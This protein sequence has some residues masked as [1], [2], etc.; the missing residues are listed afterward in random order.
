MADSIKLIFKFWKIRVYKL[1]YNATVSE[2]AKTVYLIQFDYA[3]PCNRGLMLF[4]SS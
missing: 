4:G 1:K 3:S 2:K